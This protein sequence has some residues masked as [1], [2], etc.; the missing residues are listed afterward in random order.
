M[1]DL[2]KRE[3][4][5]I[6]AV[7]PHLWQPL[8]GWQYLTANNTADYVLQCGAFHMFDNGYGRGNFGNNEENGGVLYG[9][10]A[11]VMA[12]ETYAASYDDFKLLS[13][14]FDRVAD[15]LEAEDYT[16]KPDAAHSEYLQTPLTD[17]LVDTLC[18]ARRGIEDPPKP[19]QL[20]KYGEHQ[21]NNYQNAS[22]DLPE[23][24]AYLYAFV[25][26]LLS[27]VI[28]AFGNVLVHGTMISPASADPVLVHLPSDVL[29]RWPSA[30]AEV[31]VDGLN[32]FGQRKS[33]ACRR[34]G[35]DLVCAPS[36]APF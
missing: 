34:V 11:F 16:Q 8:R 7:D 2:E 20:D 25:Q 32:V 5:A 28:D 33:L 23:S 3:R 35:A 1:R 12:A 27:L 4:A 22:H 19:N 18:R 31:H 36:D 24:S 6:E 29:G 26:G 13:Q 17:E 14:H 21:C 15:Q 30:V 9:T 10:T